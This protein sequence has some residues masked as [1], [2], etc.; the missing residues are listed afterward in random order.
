VPAACVLAVT[1]VPAPGGSRRVDAE[2]LEQIGL[3]LGEAGYAALA[4]TR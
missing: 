3:R 4:T 1:D 2:Q